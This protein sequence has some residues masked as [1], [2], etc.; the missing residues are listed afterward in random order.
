VKKRF[1]TVM[2][3]R[4][5][6]DATAEVRPRDD[7]PL[8][9]PFRIGGVVVP[10]RVVQAPLAGI[11]DQ[12]FRLQA[13]RHG[14]GLVVSE[15][16]A[17]MGLHHRNRRTER[18]LALHPDERITSIQVFGGD[19]AVMAEAA[20][21]VE[22][23]GASMVDVNMGCPVPKICRTGAGAAL[24]G[25][26]DHA[27]RVVEAMAR[28]VA[29]PV[30]VKMR[31]GL[32]PGEARPVDAARRFEAAGAAALAVHPRAAAEEYS[33]VSDHRVTA[34][35]AAAVT[36]P[37]IASGDITTPERAAEVLSTTGC[38]AVMIGRAALGDPWVLGAMADGG[39]RRRPDLAGVVAEVVAFAED[40]RRLMGDGRACHHM[41][42]FYPWYLAG[43]DVP[44]AEV[45]R[46]LVIEDL[47]EALDALR[48]LAGLP[49][50]AR[51][52]PMRRE[53]AIPA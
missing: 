24:L 32:T 10:N 2:A 7:W 25:D 49:P 19:P 3:A 44:P 34:E 36:I 45:Q 11:G 29:I 5:P 13:H 38:A 31:R 1:R 26:L 40:V 14:A 43:E 27:A 6:G 52:R 41:R 47:D 18:M 33:G 46:L 21:A 17:A 16:V 48:A 23:A 22:A 53:A 28:A 39:G 8:A 50:V 51:A 30:T 4:V 15:M 35:V 9:A 37:V 42:K 20:R 12:A